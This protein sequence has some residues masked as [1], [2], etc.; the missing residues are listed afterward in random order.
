LA[1]AFIAKR[2][3]LSGHMFRH[4]IYLALFQWI[5]N[6][7]ALALLAALARCAGRDRGAAAISIATFGPATGS[8]CRERNDW[9]KITP[10][11]QMGG[12]ESRKYSNGSKGLIRSEIPGLV[13]E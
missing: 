1:A 2:Q 12:M 4:L 7:G 6:Y 5:L 3:K 10:A 11:R 8:G 9:T 13:P